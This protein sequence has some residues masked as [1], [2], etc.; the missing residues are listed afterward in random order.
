MRKEIFFVVA[1][2]MIGVYSAFA[3]S[4]FPGYFAQTYPGTTVGN[5]SCSGCNSSVPN[6]NSTYGTAI[7]NAGLRGNS[8]LA[9]FKTSAHATDNADSDH[10]GFT[11]LAEITATPSTNLGDAAN[12]PAPTPTTTP[13]PTPTPTPPVG[14]MPCPTGEDVLFFAA[15]TSP[16]P[17]SDPAAALPI[18]VVVEPGDDVDF[19]VNA[20]RNTEWICTRN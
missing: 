10:D 15:G 3:A 14:A 12:H 16:V 19:L 1:G 4:Q 11:N 20:S 13:T 7:F 8:T 18:G 9:Q 6:L 17:S 5:F 2:L